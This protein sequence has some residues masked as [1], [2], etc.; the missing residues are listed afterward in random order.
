MVDWSS[1]YRCI[2]PRCNGERT[3]VFPDIANNRQRHS[4]WKTKLCLTGSIPLSSRI[5]RKHFQTNDFHP[6]GRIKKEAISMCA[7]STMTHPETKTS[8]TKSTSSSTT[9]PQAT[10]STTGS[11][12]SSST[13]APKASVV[14]Q[15]SPAV[16]G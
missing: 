12:T 6:S 5:C 14:I 3:V 10:T 11:A 2:A 16:K 1:K 9:N 13:M 7:A 4:E 15:L 8:T